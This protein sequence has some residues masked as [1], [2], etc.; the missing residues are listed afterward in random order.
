[1]R[2][3]TARH[4]SR[5][6][7]FAVLIMALAA[8]ASSLNAQDADALLNRLAK[9]Y[10]ELPAYG[11]QGQVGLI[12]QA[13]KA[14]AKQN[15]RV[16]FQRPGKLRVESDEIRLSIDGDKITTVID[17]LRNSQAEKIS[18]MPDADTLL[19]GPLGSSLLGSPLGHPQSILLHLL[20]DKS[21]ASWLSREGKPK[22]EP[23][24][25]WNDRKWHRLTIDRPLRPD[26]SFWID[27]DSGLIGR[28]DVLPADPARTLISV[29]WESGE[30][31]K[32]APADKIWQLD[33]PKDYVSIDQ[34]VEGFRNEAKDAVEKK[35]KPTSEL[36]GKPAPD[37]P[38]EVI[39]ADGKTSQARLSNFKGKPV[40]I[41]IWATWCDPCRKSFP[42][43]TGTLLTLDDKSQITTI[44]LSI[45]KQPED[46]KDLAEHVRK[47]L[48][49]MGVKL[50][51]LPRTTLALD[52]EGTAAIALKAQAIPMTVLVDSKGIVRKVHVGITPAATLR[53]DLAELK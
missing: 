12:D 2:T 10:A 38:I 33:I 5:T 43:L 27:P 13:G 17:S 11:D 34:K 53:R 47:G 52:R 46:G 24:E 4:S 8:G 16:L 1:M 51:T 44:L 6:A 50:S 7:I 30:L 40:V 41:D 19:V 45:D 25:T 28:I 39:G 36:V 22:V 48:E 42:E 35:K 31:A 15:A 37:F 32:T 26:W 23:D 20:L 9:T 49:R 29:R 3:V 14:E 21:S 18:A